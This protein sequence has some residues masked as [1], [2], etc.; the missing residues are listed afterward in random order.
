M[1]RKCKLLQTDEVVT[2]QHFANLP[3][4]AE[5]SLNNTGPSSLDLQSSHQTSVLE[6]TLQQ[7]FYILLDHVGGT[8]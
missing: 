1:E 8:L 7:R 4:P 2:L 6:D 5:W 3:K